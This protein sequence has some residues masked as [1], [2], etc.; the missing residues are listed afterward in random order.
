MFVIIFL[1]L[2]VFTKDKYA[3]SLIHAIITSSIS[4][5]FLPSILYQEEI[6]LN[7]DH[8]WGQMCAYLTK[9]YMI[10]DLLI[11]VK[12]IEYVLHHILAIAASSY[13]MYLREFGTLVLFIELN[14]FSTI[15]LNLFQMNIYPKLNGLL[16]AFFFFLTRNVWLS[17]LL[18]TQSIPD[19]YLCIFLYLH[20][21]MQIFW[22][23]KIVKVIMS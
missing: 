3:V 22:F 9:H 10:Y 4:L 23:T 5:C 13:I 14:E 18:Y 19:L 7:Q 8:F 20:Y 2:H 15:F 21:I 6:F 12:K 11:N 1:F 17:W 16:F